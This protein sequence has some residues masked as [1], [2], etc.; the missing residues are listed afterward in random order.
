MKSEELLSLYRKDER[1]EKIIRQ[2][3]NSN[4]GRFHISGLIA[5]ARSI[6]VSA[7]FGQDSITHLLILPDKESAAYFLNDIEN[8][9]GEQTLPAEKKHVLFYPTSYRK[10]YELE[11]TDNANVLLRAEVINRIT[12]GRKK[13]MII[14][15]PEALAEK[16][17]TKSFLTKNTF[18]LRTGEQV[19]IDFVMEF[20]AEYD[21][22]RVD[23]VAEPGQFTLRGG[24]IDVFSY[25]NEL[26]Y[27][28]EF[29]GNTIES[30]RTFDPESQ[31]SISKLNSISILPDIQ[32][33]SLV[34]KRDGFISLLPKD[35]VIWI[36]EIKFISEKIEHEFEKAVEAF[37]LLGKEIKHIEPHE[38]FVKGN[39]FLEKISEFNIIELGGN[40]FS[41]VAENIHFAVSPQ[42]S[43]NKNFELL[44]QDIQQNKDK[45][46]KQFI[47]SDNPKQVERIETIF[48]DIS[49]SKNLQNSIEFIPSYIALHEGFIDH[50]LKI[51]VYTDHQ[52]FER[53]HR[54]RLKDRFAK[55]ESITLKELYDLKPGDYITHIDHGI[56]R[57]DGLEKIDVNGKEQEAIRLVYKDNDLLYVSIHSLHRISKFIGKDG[58][59]PTM[60]RLGSNAWNN[61]KKKTKQRVKDIAKDLIKLYAERRKEKGFQFSPDTYMQT[62]LEASFIYEDT[63]DQLKAT[64]DVKKDM[65]AECPMDRLVCGDVGFGK[66]EVAIRAAFKSVADS[67]Q[68][69]VLVPTTILA[70]QHYKTFSERLKDFPCKVDYINRFKSSKDIKNSLKEL[71]EGKIDILIGTH[72][73]VSKDVEFKD[74]GLLVID[75]EQKFGVAAK[76]KLKQMKVNV[77]T[78]TLTATPIPRTLQF[79][80]MGARDLSIINT[81]PPNRYPIITELHVFR[82]EVIRDAIVYEISRGGQVFFVHNRVNN[83]QE[84]AGMIQRI[85]PDVKIGIGHGQ[86]EGHKL[87]EI[88]LDFIE[89]NYDVLVATTIIESGLD[90]SNANTIIINNAQNY[91]LSDLHQLRGRVGR[92]NK[93]AFC[94]LLAPPMSVLTDEARKRLRAIEEFSDLGSGFNIA[95]RDLDIRGAGNLLGAEQSGFIAEIG[96]EMYHKILD[97]A[98]QELKE[99]EFKEYFKDTVVKEFV[100]DCQVETDLEILIP[101]AYVSSTRERLSLYK[102]LDNIETEEVLQQFHE[103]LIDRFGPIPVQTSE[104]FNTIRLRWVAKKLGFEKLVMKGGKLAGF[105]IVDEDSPFFQT[106][107]F[108]KILHY[109]QAN[110]RTCRMRE[111]N[112]KLTLTFENILSVTNALVRLRE[113]LNE[114]EIKK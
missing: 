5:S 50:D 109:V 74:L 79:S 110:Q 100:K 62:E 66:T 37:Q 49:K 19:N 63:P 98:V 94:Y 81:A 77:D 3:G 114:E 35:T 17:V 113:V 24:I 22:E 70:L 23:F 36:D 18:K 11:N 54:Y 105:F 107:I 108:T 52:I 38:L 64:N 97:E 42:P 78:L 91:G 95:M 76:E 61:L 1:T 68:V 93:K 104:L 57:Y 7:V 102:D 84:V 4:N 40:Y 16:V 86:L 33:S 111:G 34:E 73:L 10:A 39:D 26:P 45:G 21:F 72:R 9:F 13:N 29:A 58:T 60:N 90:I 92:T 96:F 53:Y 82:E 59:E 14:T 30:L 51:I 27:R 106:E 46:Y 56:G 25:S 28:I 112:K 48:D 89:G 101:D 69:A 32:N 43:F 31:L 6:I 87:E 2:L 103:N 85:C 44:I 12:S 75:E 67:K 71:K 55:K 65:E 8:I 20:L 47:L 88:M 80:M 41:G 83:I 15:Y 99:T